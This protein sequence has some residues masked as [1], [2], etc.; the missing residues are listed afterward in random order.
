MGYISGY[1]FVKS[2]L[3][4]QIFLF[5]FITGIEYHFLGYF[6]LPNFCTGPRTEKFH[7]EIRYR[8]TSA[9]ISP[10]HSF[11]TFLK[12]GDSFITGSFLSVT[13]KTASLPL[14]LPLANRLPGR[15]E[16]KRGEISRTISIS[17]GDN[18]QTTDNKPRTRFRGEP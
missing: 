16:R 7:P 10:V 15:E 14:S 6:S 12:P 18:R 13:I 8:N 3:S 5:P 17:G 4:R 2:S 11:L 9:F 1:S